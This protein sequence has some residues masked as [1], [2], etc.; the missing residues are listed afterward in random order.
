MKKTELL[1]LFL[2]VLLSSYIFALKTTLESTNQ[3]KS[4][5]KLTLQSTFKS[6]N[7]V[8]TELKSKELIA[9]SSTDD[10]DVQQEYVAFSDYRCIFR[11]KSDQESLANLK[12]KY[13]DLLNNKEEVTMNDISLADVDYYCSSIKPL[14]VIKL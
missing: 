7:Q 14:Y 3:A 4:E 11:C 12:Q 1:I 6:K 13:L 8:K 9:N 2:F 10:N 5:G